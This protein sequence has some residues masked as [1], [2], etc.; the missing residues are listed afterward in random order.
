MR[1]LQPGAELVVKIALGPNV[2]EMA[3]PAGSV[4]GG[5]DDPRMAKPAP[6]READSEPGLA[7]IQARESYPGDAHQPRLLRNHLYVAERLEE[8][9]VLARQLDDT[10]SGTCEQV[11]DREVAAR[12][13]QILADQPCA[14]AGACPDRAPRH[15]GGSRLGPAASWTPQLGH[16]DSPVA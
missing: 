5:L 4:V 9:Y 11:P 15:V 14:A 12:V 6:Q 3:P 7:G 2:D 16:F 10:G 13:P 8:A 1:L